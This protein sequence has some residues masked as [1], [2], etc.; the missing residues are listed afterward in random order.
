MFCQIF[1]WVLGPLKHLYQRTL[2]CGEVTQAPRHVVTPAVVHPRGV[3]TGDGVASDWSTHPGEHAAELYSHIS[4]HFADFL[5]YQAVTR[6]LGACVTSP[7]PK[8][9]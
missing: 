5:G 4:S 9:R 1:Y 7:H 3:P 6:C 8:V 2:G